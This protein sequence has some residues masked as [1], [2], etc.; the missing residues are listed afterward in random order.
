MRYIKLEEAIIIHEKI[1]EK[2]GGLSGFNNTQL[3]YLESA[4]EHIKN[5]NYYPTLA[6]KITHLMFSCIKFHPFTDGNKRTSIF[7]AM[8][9]LDL[10]DKYN[11]KFAIVMEDIVVQVADG[12]ILK[13]ELREILINFINK[14]NQ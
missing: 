2:T 12:S 7:L 5:D 13:D 8:H 3:G 6:D 14:Y 10:D 4:L 9:F 11:E 1:I